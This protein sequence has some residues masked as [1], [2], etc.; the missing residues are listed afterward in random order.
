MLTQQQVDRFR[1]VLLRMKIAASVVGSIRP[2]LSDLTNEHTCYYIQA[3][4]DATALL[5]ELREL[6]AAD[7]EGSDR[8]QSEV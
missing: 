4:S 8:T 3:D 6:E 5:E 7:M 2:D 1:D